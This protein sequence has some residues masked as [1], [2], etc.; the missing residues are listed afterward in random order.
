LGLPGG[1]KR[2]V[3]HRGEDDADSEKL[4]WKKKLATSFI[5][6][7][8]GPEDVC[9]T[10]GG[11]IKKIPASALRA[12]KSASLQRGK[13]S[14]RKRRPHRGGGDYCVG[15]QRGNVCEEKLLEVA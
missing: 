8:G 3:S 2:G 13:I 12:R 1:G 9:E 14:P 7:K 4:S 11:R 5:E 10:A 6:K 15:R